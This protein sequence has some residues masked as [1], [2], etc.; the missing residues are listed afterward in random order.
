VAAVAAQ[1][2]PS[3]VTVMAELATGFGQSG[4]V[5]TGIIATSDGEIVTNAHVVEGATSL[6]VRLAGETEPREAT[7]LAIDVGNDLAL[8]DIEGEGFPAAVFA[9]PG[10]IRLG[11]EVVAIG[12]ALDLDGAP[13]VT[14]GIVSALNRTLVTDVGALDGLLQTDAAIS[15][16][17]SGGPLVNAA[18]EVVGINTAVARGSSTLAASNIGFSISVDEA[19]PIFE[20][21][22]KQSRG[23]QRK[24]GFLGV[25]L[26]ERIDGG[27][28]AVIRDV[29]V[30]TPADAAGLQAGDIVIA[31]DGATV[32]GAAGLIAAIRDLEPGDSVQITVQ[33]SDERL[34]VVA[35]LTSRPTS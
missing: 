10:S 27:V 19:L 21:L 7:L 35:E 26:D 12:F 13:T 14:L 16:G 15:S 8:L 23:E 32:E 25:A 29:N 22:R 1:V 2:G 9:R 5:G 30:G 4:S 3:T 34:E 33:R 31:V 18:G 20:Q 28:G 6:R 17:N 24:E 11:D